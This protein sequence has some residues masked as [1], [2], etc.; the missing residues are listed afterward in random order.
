Q[1]GSPRALRIWGLCASISRRTVRAAE[2]A[3]T[4]AL[5]E[6][7][8]TAN[9]SLS[10]SRPDRAFQGSLRWTRPP[11]TGRISRA[12]KSDRAQRRVVR[13]HPQ[14]LRPDNKRRSDSPP[15]ARTCTGNQAVPSGVATDGTN[16]YW[17]NQSANNGAVQKC[18]VGGC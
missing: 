2:G 14:H 5:E 3:G 13:T 1:R 6:V 12:D 7:V 16:V 8:P 11:S 10:F 17:T 9:V 15:T 4:I 18:S